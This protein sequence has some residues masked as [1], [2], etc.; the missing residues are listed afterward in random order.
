MMSSTLNIAHLCD[1]RTLR[2][3]AIKQQVFSKHFSNAVIV[4]VEG[5]DLK[6]AV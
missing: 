2:V 3:L 6:S 1:G 5:V 4:D